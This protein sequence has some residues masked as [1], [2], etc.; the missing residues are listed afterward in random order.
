MR[1]KA[2]I[3]KPRADTKAYVLGHNKG[4]VISHNLMISISSFHYNLLKNSELTT[5]LFQG[6]GNLKPKLIQEEQ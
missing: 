3:S 1:H 6:C 5:V 4:H 2:F